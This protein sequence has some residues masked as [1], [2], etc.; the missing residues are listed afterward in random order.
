MSHDIL[1][2]RFV[3]REGRPVWH[4]LGTT[5]DGPTTP[6]QA[7]QLAGAD[8]LVTQRPLYFPRD[9]EAI[10]IP[11]QYAIIRGELSEHVGNPDELNLEETGE[12]FLG[13]STDAFEIIQNTEVAAML[14]PLAEKYPVETVGCL[15]NGARLFIVLRSTTPAEV[16]GEE[17]VNFFTISDT[18]IPGQRARCFYTPVCTVCQNTLLSAESASTINIRIAH[19]EGAAEEME[20]YTKMMIEMATTQEN[21]LAQF[22]RMTQKKVVGEDLVT[23]VNTIHPTPSKPRR[24]VSIDP[25]LLERMAADNVAGADA[26]LDRYK[27]S[28][29]N[30]EAHVARTNE[31]RKT[32]LDL[33]QKFNDERS[34]HA[35]TVWALYNAATELADWREG[36]GK[37]AE[38][39]LFGIRAQ[40]KVLAYNVC[41]DIVDDN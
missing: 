2:Q 26:Q 14:D 6:S 8:F 1:G 39:A 15:A 32:T 25:V 5:F 23:A 38:S 20:F 13:L 41:M 27:T 28:E 40:E 24:L 17:I 31:M 30:Y 29:M 3:A 10:L 37:I 11:N 34:A 36:R 12:V 18:K 21:V 4:G 22:T 16:G 19:R 7:V 33:V 35:N 9:G